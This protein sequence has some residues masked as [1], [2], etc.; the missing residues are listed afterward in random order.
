MATFPSRPTIRDVGRI[1]KV[2][3]GTVSR[4]LRGR[5]GV[6]DETRI[7]VEKVARQIGYQASRAARALPAGKTHFIGYHIASDPFNAS[8]ATLLH[9]MVQAASRADFE[10]LLF[11]SKPGQSTLDASVEVLQR[12]V[13]G[14]VLSYLRPDD[15]RI[16]LFESRDIEYVAFGHLPRGARGSWVDSAGA[17]GIARAV[18]HVAE[19]GHQRVG[20]VGWPEGQWVTGDIRYRGYVEAV[21]ELGLA[22]DP[23]LVVRV[24]GYAPEEGRRAF[25]QIVAA[26]PTAVVAV[27]DNLAIGVMHAAEDLGLG[28][29]TDLAVVGY[30]DIP[31]ASDVRPSLTTLRQ[32]VQTIG[33]RLVEVLLRRLDNPGS[34]PEGVEIQPE[35]V[36]RSSTVP[37]SPVVPT[38]I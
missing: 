3:P 33:T 25:H 13:D 5:P 9:A 29:G 34:E 24:G 37:A 20:F 17:A 15:P 21:T 12:G 26:R 23:A 19:L 16:G 31:A 8:M 1:A 27:S 18:H 7:R 35:L 30:D 6:S 14:F 28:V 11:S 36:I 2:S 22:D 38:Q 32:P 4:A 10:M